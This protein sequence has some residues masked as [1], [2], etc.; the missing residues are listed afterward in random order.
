VETVKVYLCPFRQT[1]C[2]KELCAIYI[3]DSMTCGIKELVIALEDFTI[4]LSTI[5]AETIGETIDK[6]EPQYDR[7]V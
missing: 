2:L 6:E 7:V 1:T 4:T 5:L 3:E